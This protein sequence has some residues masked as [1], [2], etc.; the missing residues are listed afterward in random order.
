MNCPIQVDIGQ[1]FNCSVR[2]NRI[3]SNLTDCILDF[4]N[5]ES[6]FLD[7]INQIY[8]I[9]KTFCYEGTYMIIL[10]VNNSCIPRLS[11][12]VKVVDGKNFLNISK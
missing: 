7:K 9:S 10:N 11:Q 8:S 6:V 1:E 12:S 2:Y 5:G 4:G 3:N